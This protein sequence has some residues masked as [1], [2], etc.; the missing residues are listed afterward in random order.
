MSIWIRLLLIVSAKYFPWAYNLYSEN[1]KKFNMF[2]DNGTKFVKE[3]VDKNYDIII[4]DLSNPYFYKDYE[5]FIMLSSN[6]L[7][8][9]K[10]FQNMYKLLLEN[11]GVV[12]ENLIIS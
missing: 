10:H 3:Y 9:T 6:A 7:Y 12:Y 5:S 8:S 1:S 4:Q 2:I 11:G